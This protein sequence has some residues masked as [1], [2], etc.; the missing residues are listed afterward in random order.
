MSSGSKI[1]MNGLHT[2]CNSCDAKK[3]DI[4]RY[5]ILMTEFHHF[6]WIFGQAVYYDSRHAPSF[7][8]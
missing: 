7:F 4:D 8:L 2:V 1:I 6:S 3:V 5:K